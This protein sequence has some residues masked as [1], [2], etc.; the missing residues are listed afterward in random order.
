MPATY[1]TKRSPL[2]EGDDGK[3]IVNMNVEGMPWYHKTSP[4]TQEGGKRDQGYQ[5]TKEES[6]AYL[7]GAL[8]A[9]LAVAAIFAVVFFLFILFCDLV[10]FK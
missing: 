4:E 5:M 3:T 7:W 10:W 6:R 2:P 9:T 8:K 1:M